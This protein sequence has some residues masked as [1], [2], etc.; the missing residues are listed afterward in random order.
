MGQR[1]PD[2]PK[3]LRVKLLAIRHKLE[4]S[5]FQMAKLLKTDKGAIRIEQYETGVCEP[6]LLVLLRYAILAQVPM[7]VLINDKVELTFS[8]DWIPLSRVELIQ[9]IK[10][11]RAKREKYVGARLKNP[12]PHFQSQ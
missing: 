12:L 10:S 11:G 6:D 8:K 3:Y 7:A 2:A 1:E 5:R 9:K 4:A